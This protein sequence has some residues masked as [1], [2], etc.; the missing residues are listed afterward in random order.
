MTMI[1]RRRIFCWRSLQAA[2]CSTPKAGGGPRRPTEPSRQPTP[3][4][5]AAPQG[6]CKGAPPCKGAHRAGALRACTLPASSQACLRKPGPASCL[7]RWR[8]PRSCRRTKRRQ[9]EEAHGDAAAPARRK[10]QQRAKNDDPCLAPF[11]RRSAG[12]SSWPSKRGHACHSPSSGIS[13][14]G[15]PSEGRERLCQAVFPPSPAV[16]AE[17]LRWGAAAQ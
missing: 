4:V 1:I 13:R 3:L 9:R 14:P 6:P 2:R 12:A 15:A 10:H 17:P 7:G 8:R 16:A 5:G 11:C